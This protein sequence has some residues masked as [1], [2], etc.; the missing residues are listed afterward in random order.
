MREGGGRGFNLQIQK[1]KKQF[2]SILNFLIIY[3]QDC[4]KNDHT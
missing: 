1:D 4:L 3:A 2:N